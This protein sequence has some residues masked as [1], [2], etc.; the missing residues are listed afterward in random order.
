MQVEVAVL[1]GLQASGKST[2]CRTVLADGRA[3]VSK[4]DF[5]NARNRQRRQLRLVGEALVA[6][7]S[8]VVDNTNPSP[9]QWQPLIEAAR[10]HG[11]SVA[12]Y[13]FPPDPAGSAARNAVRDDR[14]RVPAAGLRAVLRELRRPSR[15]DGF[16]RLYTVGFDGAGGFRV[17]VLEEER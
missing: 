13:W 6:G 4:D 1:I 16:D 8:V 5:R 14:T 7:R 10:E 17:E 15:A 11:A 3:V 12:G 2:F 9:E